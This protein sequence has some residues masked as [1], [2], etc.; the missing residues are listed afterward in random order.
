MPKAVHKCTC[1]PLHDP[2]VRPRDM[3]CTPLYRSWKSGWC[4]GK[5]AASAASAAGLFDH[6]RQHGPGGGDADQPRGYGGPGQV[7]GGQ[8]PHAPVCRTPWVF[9]LAPSSSPHRPVIPAVI[10]HNRGP[11]PHVSMT[12]LP[13][14]RL[15]TC[16][17]H[18][19]RSQPCTAWLKLQR[20][21]WQCRAPTM[22]H[23]PSDARSQRRCRC[24]V[25]P[26]P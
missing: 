7:S 13:R 3:T 24:R 17:R 5:G 10:I 25:Q 14:L 11:K 20:V 1:P 8:P 16:C 15:V 19:C 23:V 9:N 2:C 12:C 26:P 18:L 6:P 22:P 21:A 4:P